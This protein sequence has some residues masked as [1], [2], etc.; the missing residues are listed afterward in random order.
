MIKSSFVTWIFI[1]SGAWLSAQKYEPVTVRAG[2]KVVDCFPFNERY[3]YPEFKA[4]RITLLNGVV[5][6]KLLN[7]DFLNGEVEYIRGKDTLAIANTKDIKF[8][9]VA[10]DTFYYSR[11]VYLE[12]ISGGNIKVALRQ[13]I[14][15]K[16]TQKKDSYGTASSGSSTNSYGSLPKEGDF[17]MLV[18]NEDMVFQRTLEYYISDA[19]GGFVQ[20]SKKNLMHVYSGQ[21]NAL[22]EYLKSNKI[23]FDKRED[24]VRLADYL[25]SQ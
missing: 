9:S 1:L 4:G 11:G 15:L 5:S 14:K 3:R 19:A 18:A 7:Y 23:S 17:H 20:F 10:T 12:R 8:I 16:E 13:Y 24:L 25:K 6:D 22:K 21:Q 2:M